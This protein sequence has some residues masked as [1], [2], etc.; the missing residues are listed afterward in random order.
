MSF[1]GFALLQLFALLEQQ[2]DKIC[3]FRG[4]LKLKKSCFAD[5]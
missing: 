3:M 5:C 2:T 1:G 4:G